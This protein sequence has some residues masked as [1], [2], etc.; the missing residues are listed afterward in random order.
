MSQPQLD[1]VVDVFP[2]GEPGFVEADGVDNV[3]DEKTVDD[4]SGAILSDDGGLAQAGADVDG[5]GQGFVA[6]EDAAH[7]FQ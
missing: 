1:G 4:E 7:Q 5:E 2:G 3:G 6:G